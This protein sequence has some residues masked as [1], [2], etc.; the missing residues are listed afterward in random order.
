MGAMRAWP[1]LLLALLGCRGDAPQPAEHREPPPAEGQTV[2][3]ERVSDRPGNTDGVVFVAMYHRVMPEE[4][5]YTRSKENFKKDLQ[6]LYDM[7][8][9]PV[10][11][12]EYLDDTMDLAP[13]ASPVVM[14][15]DDSTENQFRYLPDG[16]IDPECAVGLWLE[17]AKSHPD[18]P[19]KG[20]FYVNANGPFE[21]D[22]PKK[23]RQ[24]LEWGCD[25]DSHTMT[26]EYLDRVDDETV[27]KELGGMQDYLRALGVNNPRVLCLPFGLSP[28][29]RSLLRSFEWNGKRY[30]H[31]A[32]LLVGW[33]PAPSPRDPDRDPFAIPRIQA[34]DGEM[35]LTFWLDEVEKGNVEPYV[36]P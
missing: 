27:K 28:K 11:L 9:R 33:K 31:E 23:V 18:F 35:G 6:R 4:G 10:T 14:T 15:W 3:R 20:S 36:Q 21:R 26:H 25:V 34:Y 1:F 5:S 24:L 16:S 2:A 12:G 13:G 7:G 19:V 32:A 22:G 29:D 8:F 30:A 17:F